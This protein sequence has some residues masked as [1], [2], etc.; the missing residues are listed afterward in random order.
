MKK[1]AIMWTVVAAGSLVGCNNNRVDEPLVEERPQIS[2]RTSNREIVEG[3]VTTLSV[4]SKNTL[5]RDAEV[6]WNTTGGNLTTADNGRIA[7][8]TFEE[9]GVYT[10]TARLLVDGQEVDREATNITVRPLK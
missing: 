6:E 4:Y 7:R 8:V 3:E 9:A 2:L 5:G 1:I 10:I